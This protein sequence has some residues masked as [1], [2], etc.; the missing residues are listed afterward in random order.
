[1]TKLTKIEGIGQSSAAKLMA[2]GITS[3]EALL[4]AGNTPSGRKALVNQ[5]QI[6]RRLILK[7]VNR[8][9]LSRIKGI[10]E[11]YADLLEASGVDTV[12]DLARRN[13][14][15]LHV[16]LKE[17]NRNRRLVRRVPT[18]RQVTSW[19]AQAA[20]LPRIIEY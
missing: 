13:S 4:E 18:V 19:V 20:Q 5:V 10:G 16:K 9:D 15:N 12:P 1:M 8:A 3:V 14:E 11:E 17:V 7:W 6:S 2:A